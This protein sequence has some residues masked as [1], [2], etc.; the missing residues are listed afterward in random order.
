M[1]LFYTLH[2]TYSLYII[3]NYIM[4][5][6][7]MYSLHIN[8]YTMYSLYVYKYSVSLYKHNVSCIHISCTHTH[9]KTFN[10]Y[11]LNQREISFFLI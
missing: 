2:I 10:M 7:I 3:S 5:L 1:Y 11:K 4:Q 8:I 6:Y 9:P